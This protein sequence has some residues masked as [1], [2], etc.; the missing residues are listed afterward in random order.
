MTEQT[1]TAEIAVTDA[2]LAD[3]RDVLME[4]GFVAAEWAPREKVVAKIDRKFGLENWLR[5]YGH[6]A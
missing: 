2:A 3:M 1:A 5:H 4:M 6:A